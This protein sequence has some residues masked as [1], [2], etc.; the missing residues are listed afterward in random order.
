MEG[1]VHTAIVWKYADNGGYTYEGKDAEKEKSSL[2]AEQIAND[3]Q[4]M[5]DEENE[6]L[7]S[8]EEL[9]MMIEEELQ[10]MQEEE[11]SVEKLAREKARKDSEKR[12]VD[13]KKVDE[14]KAADNVG[15]KLKSTLDQRGKRIVEIDDMTVKHHKRLLPNGWIDVEFDYIEIARSTVEMPLLEI[16]EYKHSRYNRGEVPDAMGQDLVEK[17][18]GDKHGSFGVWEFFE[19]FATV[20]KW[21]KVLAHGESRDYDEEDG[22]LSS[23]ATYVKGVRHGPYKS[24]WSNNSRYPTGDWEVSNYVNGVQHGPVQYYHGINNGVLFGTGQYS[25]GKQAGKWI[26]QYDDGA[27]GITYYENGMKKWEDLG[28]YICYYDSNGMVKN[29]VLKNNQ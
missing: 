23:I 24:H 17:Y 28:M 1:A 16:V 19:N 6:G 7:V 25:N 3:M 12:S 21:T 29:S 5:M 11:D 15:Q 10:K 26:I 8:N 2:L 20:D 14:N 22:T 27:K 4:G 13:D 18:F 9:K